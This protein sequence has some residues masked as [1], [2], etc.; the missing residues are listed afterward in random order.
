MDQRRWNKQKHRW[1]DRQNN[2]FCIKSLALKIVT[3]HQLVGRCEYRRACDDAHGRHRSS[4][5]PS[6]GRGCSDHEAPR[7]PAPPRRSL[8]ERRVERTGVRSSRCPVVPVGGGGMPGS[9]REHVVGI[10]GSL[11]RRPT[12]MYHFTEGFYDRGFC[13]DS[14]CYSMMMV[15]KYWRR[16]VFSFRWYALIVK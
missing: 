11:A 2:R 14:C 8:C 3:I 5:R 1:H 6:G 7:S 10:E 15:L 4:S 12:R 9:H 16:D 13:I